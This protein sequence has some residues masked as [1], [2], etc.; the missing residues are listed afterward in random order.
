MIAVLPKGGVSDIFKPMW[1]ESR[2]IESN[3]KLSG[4][5]TKK[6]QAH[7]K[8]SFS[9]LKPSTD[10][11]YWQ[12][13][14]EFFDL[15]GTEESRRYFKILSANQILFFNIQTFIYSLSPLSGVS[16]HFKSFVVKS[17]FDTSRA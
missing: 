5:W 11:Q 7:S 2:P 8:L 10:T 1:P 16:L 17:A 9:D 3:K 13:R 15:K 4:V 14:K 12:I 6:C